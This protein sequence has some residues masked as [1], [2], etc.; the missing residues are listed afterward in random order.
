M[1]A[2]AEFCKRMMEIWRQR[3]KE[4]SENADLEA[5]EFAEREIAN[6]REMLSRYEQKG[7]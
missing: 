3:S 1:N 5:F 7:D 6:Y 2:A 4:A